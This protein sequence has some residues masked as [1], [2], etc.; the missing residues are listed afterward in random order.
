MAFDKV[1]QLLE[2]KNYQIIRVET[3]THIRKKNSGKHRDGDVDSYKI[4]ICKCPTEGCTETI[5]IARERDLTRNPKCRACSILGSKKKDKQKREWYLLTDDINKANTLL[6]KSNPELFIREEGTLTKH[7]GLAK[8]VVLKC[9][10]SD[11]KGTI[12]TNTINRITPKHNRC[13]QCADDAKKKRPFERTYNGAKRKSERLKSN[14]QY[15]KWLLSY[16]EFI[17]LCQIPY[18]HYCSKLLNRAEFKRDNGSLSV[19]LDRKD[20]GKDYTFDNCV[21]CCPDCNFTKN[22]HI[23]YD[24]MVLIMKH[25]GLWIEKRHLKIAG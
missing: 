15:I 22:E 12:T 5:K 24:E 25:R 4:I 6:A 2:E 19:L 1:M 8:R 11:C 17:C 10:T 20:S 7:K 14:G 3:K 23:S 9:F 16:E 18:C 13:R 21:P